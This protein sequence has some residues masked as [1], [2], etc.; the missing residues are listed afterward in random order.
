MRRGVQF[1]LV[2]ALLA[3]AASVSAQGAPGWQLRD[4]HSIVN[5]AGDGSAV[6]LERLDLSCLQMAP[7]K[8][9][10][11]IQRLI[12]VE[13]TGP[14]GTKRRLYLK[15]LGVTD[16]DGHTLPYRV[17]I[18]GGQTEIRVPMLGRT[19][20]SRTVEVGY[21]IHNAVRYNPD[22]DEVYWNLTSSTL[23]M[24]AEQ[25]SATVFLPE[26][27][28]EGLRAQGFIS[29]PYGGT[30][31]G[32]VNGASVEFV[33]PRGVGAHE[34]FAVEVV[35]PKGVFHR[36]WWPWRAL[37][38]MESNPILFMPLMVFLVMLWIR[39]LKGNLPTVGVVTEYEPPQGL[40]P[41][42]AGT[43]LTDRVEPR[44]ITATLLDLAVRGYVKIEEDNSEGHP[45][46]IIRLMKPRDQWRG[47]TN[48]E[49]DMLFNT[50]YG[51]QWTKLS[52]L[53]LRFVVAVPSMRTGILN[54]LIDK[55]MYRV[56]PVSAQ[57]YRMVLAILVGLL[58][59]AVPFTG[60]IKLYDAG[61]LAVALV[62]ASVLIVYVM[63]RNL[64]AKSLVGMR[65]CAAVEGFREFMERV[66][67]DR[68]KRASPKQVERCLPYA[69][70][71]GVEHNWAEHFAGITEEWPEWLVVARAEGIDP[72]RWTR[73]LGSMAQEAETVFTAQ[74]RTGRYPKRDLCGS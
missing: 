49:I 59:L 74:T 56:D 33:A 13:S 12:P 68:L 16:G 6:I 21:F 55:G 9:F 29:G 44:D 43:L 31:S 30:L 34:A 60:W 53:K 39:R 38:F 19:G 7:G 63:G 51:G 65:A 73:S 69:M 42:E 2:G 67:A 1:G 11:G 22:H 28:I 48:Y 15:A 62:A 32:Q 64:T 18:W 46:Y 50:F 25:A 24:P 5:V 36:P 27:A 72:T 71:L 52:S 10:H 3:L 58:L 61:P 20:D 37:W 17:R 66:D 54:A 8:E 40:T 47:L 35:V 4:F 14:L 45:D 23:P 26:K 57:V 41:A 70:A